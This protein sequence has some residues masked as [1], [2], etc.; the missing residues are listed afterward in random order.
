MTIQTFLKEHEASILD[1]LTKLLRQPSIS[2]TGEG[3]AACA[4]VVARLMRDAGLDTK[5]HPT[6]G[7]PVVVGRIEGDADRTLLI[8]GHYDVQPP[9]PL[10]DWDFNPFG[11][12]R[13]GNRIYARGA[14][15]D[16]GN[17][18]AAVEAI[19]YYTEQGRRP[20]INVV[21]VIEGEEE[22]SSPNLLDFLKAHRDEFQADALIDLDD[23]V[24][25]D[26]RPKIVTGMKGICYVELSV[27][28]EREFHSL[29][30]P[31]LINPAW[32]L[33]WALAS[34]KDADETITIDD[35]YEDVRDPTPA[36]E[37]ALKRLEYDGAEW[38]TDAKQQRFVGGR[39]PDSA[40]HAFFF[41]PSCNICGLVGGYT[42]EG[43]KTV[44]PKKATAKIDF[45]LVPDQ[46]PQGVLRK[47]RDHLDARGFT[48]VTIEQ[49]GATPWYRN[50]PEVPVALALRQ[51]VDDVFPEGA[52]VWVTYAG[53]GPAALF[54]EALN[55]PQA[56]TGFGPVGDR[57]H[58]PNE[59][60]TTD[61]YFSA[62]EVM[63][64]AYEYF[65]QLDPKEG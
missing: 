58:A 5:I 25:P 56:Y 8:Y 37:R 36:E 29:M 65:A 50:S 10:E 52:A 41:L 40:M 48:D 35:F 62:I 16:K 32:R 3:M 26:G 38:L 11:A 45:R 12:E 1:N 2:A 20:P 63:V 49:L 54:D 27:R 13:V 53:S 28:S 47:L 60:M 44:I 4:E 15:D 18:L 6:P 42:G 39:D 30:S 57:I 9:D 23:C 17:F 24:Q 59:Y 61:L 14:I 33:T 46:T 34:L 51:A 43:S 19:R 21:V 31:L 64:L 55:I 7:Y 22:I